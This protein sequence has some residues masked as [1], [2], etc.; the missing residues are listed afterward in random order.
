MNVFPHKNRTMKKSLLRGIGIII[1]GAVVLCGMGALWDAS[2]AA[3][4]LFFSSSSQVSLSSILSD[5]DLHN[6]S[7]SLPNDFGKELFAL[8]AFFDVR[9]SEEGGVIGLLSHGSLEEVTTFCE[10]E[11][12]EHGWTKVE[13]GYAACASFVKTQGSYTWLFMSCIE[14]CGDTSILISLT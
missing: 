10:A 13:S 1:C 2:K 4:K 12:I 5:Q 6:D 7:S 8:D 11:L 9:V 3:T 14:V